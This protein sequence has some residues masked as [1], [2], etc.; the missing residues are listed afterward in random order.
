MANSGRL[1]QEIATTTNGFAY[2]YDTYSKNIRQI[3]ILYQ[4]II[5][6]KVSQKDIIN[7]LGKI[8]SNLSTYTR[9]FGA[10][11]SKF[12]KQIAPQI[13]AKS[14]EITNDFIKLADA[15][16]KQGNSKLANKIDKHLDKIAMVDDIEAFGIHN[17][18]ISILAKDY[19]VEIADFS[20]KI[21]ANVIAD[22]IDNKIAEL[23]EVGELALSTRYCPDHNGVQAIRISERTYQCPIDGKVYNYE[24]GFTNYKGQKI[25]GGNV[26]A[27]TQTT[28]DYGGIPMVIYDNRHSVLNR[29]Y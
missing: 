8:Y 13:I 11:V 26:S 4:N 9:G 7:Q 16:D 28:S 25:P 10:L 3:G 21:G 1:A 18:M 6:N 5:N 23:V 17:D 22:E 2:A 27:Q 24:T 15:F 29:I 19:N 14:A 12:N 20:D